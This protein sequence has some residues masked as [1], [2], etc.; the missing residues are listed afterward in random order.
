MYVDIPRWI[1][2]AIYVWLSYQL[3]H[4]SQF[5]ETKRFQWAKRFTFGFIIFS[6]IWLFHLILYIIPSL[7]DTLL[8]SVGWYPV[9]IPLIVLV[10]W[11]GINGYIIGYNTFSKTK[12]QS[13][14]SRDVVEKTISSLEHSMK[15]EQLYLNPMLKLNDLVIHFGVSQ[16]V[17]SAVLNQYLGKSFNEYVNTFRVEEFKSRLLTKNSKNL[18]ITGIA[19]E[20][21]FNSQATFQRTFKAMT[22]QSPKEFQ[23]SHQ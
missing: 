12:L 18:T 22:N 9:Y 20:C 1:S 23:E 3:L 16:K 11:L 2:L 13:G 6:V 5:K 17:L 15:N 4:K 10:Y 21:G 7:S 8:N 14:L 19:L